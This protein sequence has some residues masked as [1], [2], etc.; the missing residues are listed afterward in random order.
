MYTINRA[1]KGY[2]I[3]KFSKDFDV[4][5]IYILDKSCDCPQGF[6]GYC[7]HRDILKEFIREKRIGKGY[8][9][10]WD[11]KKWHEPIGATEL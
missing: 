9:L 4:E 7:R 6:R 3:V 8:F 1:P 10:D 2:R 11:T 5:R